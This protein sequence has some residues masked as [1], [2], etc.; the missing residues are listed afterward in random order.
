MFG[1]LVGATL[2]GLTPEA[3]RLAAADASLRSRDPGLSIRGTKVPATFR[4]Y[5]PERG[6]TRLTINAFFSG[7]NARAYHSLCRHSLAPLRRARRQRLKHHLVVALQ[8]CQHRQPNLPQK[9]SQS[10]PPPRL[11][12]H[13]LHQHQLLR[14]RL[15]HQLSNLQYGRP[16]RHSMCDL[17]NPSPLLSGL[18][19]LLPHIKRNQ[20][21]HRLRHSLS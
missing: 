1:L 18:L 4:K 13:N 19:D 12:H 2:N 16:P 17:Q 20:P 8:D 15:L 9:L 10:S 7:L 11:L 3:P 6:N 21:Q 5:S 14:C